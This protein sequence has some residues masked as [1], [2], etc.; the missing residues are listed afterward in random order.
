M[1]AREW[2]RVGTEPH[3]QCQQHEFGF[4]NWVAGLD[5]QIAERLRSILKRWRGGRE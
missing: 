1:T 3:E 2:F 4:S 5:D